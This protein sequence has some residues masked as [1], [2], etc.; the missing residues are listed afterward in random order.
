MDAEKVRKI[1][2]KDYKIIESKYFVERF[3]EV[4]EI[5]G[6]KGTPG[7]LIEVNVMFHNF[8]FGYLTAMTNIKDFCENG[9][10][11]EVP[12]Q[13]R[14]CPHKEYCPKISREREFNYNEY[15]NY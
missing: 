5:P 9:F 2:E 11:E 15:N 4:G 7:N 8:Y 13:C 10:V 12:S 6:S 3:T 14:L 1:M